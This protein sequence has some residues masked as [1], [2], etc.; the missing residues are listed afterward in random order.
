MQ[1]SSCRSFWTSCPSKF[2]TIPNR[3][4]FCISLPLFLITLECVPRNQVNRLCMLRACQ[5]GWAQVCGRSRRLLGAKAEVDISGTGVTF[6]TQSSFLLNHTVSRKPQAIDYVSGINSGVVKSHLKR[7]SLQANALKPYAV[8]GG[9]FCW[10]DG[11][12]PLRYASR[13]F[14]SSIS[15]RI[16]G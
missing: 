7:F 10:A 8:H 11:I 3:P 15:T 16:A 14:L 2:A 1:L 6:N 4:A 12:R 9:C 5:P 13:S